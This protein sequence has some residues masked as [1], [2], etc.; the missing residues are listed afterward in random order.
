M[1]TFQFILTTGL[2]VYAAMTFVG[3][4]DN[5]DVRFWSFVAFGSLTVIAAGIRP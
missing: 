3:E 2:A 4:D 5:R 1:T